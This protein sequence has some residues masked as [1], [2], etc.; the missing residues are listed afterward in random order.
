MSTA[1]IRID[2]AGERAEALL[3]RIESGLADPSELNRRIARR[4]EAL[5]RDYLLEIAPE[6]HKTASKLGAEPTG[7]LERAAENV[8]SRAD[9]DAAYVGVT[10]PGI[11]RAF[12]DL[13]I[14]GHPWL[15]IPAHKLAYGR[16]AKS[17]ERL[18]G[19]RLFRPLK[20]GAR[21]KASTLSHGPGAQKDKG[22][23]HR[24]KQFAESDRAR[25]LAARVGGKLTVFYTLASQV[26]QRQDRTLL[27]SDAGYQREASMAGAEYILELA[28]VRDAGGQP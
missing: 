5:T 27:P 4:C 14:T 15:T 22:A 18:L 1:T 28:R 2:F 24:N 16:R 13:T 8:T 10:S 20:K 3:A 6:T 17:L 11:T 25:A 19:V 26:H 9:A 21:A 7:H 12:H 23:S